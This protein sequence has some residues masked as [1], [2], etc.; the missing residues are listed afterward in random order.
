V[1][2]VSL[3]STGSLFVA[4]GHGVY[5]WDGEAYVE[6]FYDSFENLSDI[7][8]TAE[9]DVWALTW[10]TVGHFDGQDWTW[11]DLEDT[12]LRELWVAPTGEA[13][14]VG[15]NDFR[16]FDEDGA[17]QL[18][19]APGELEELEAIF[20]ASDEDLWAVGY[21]TVLRKD[22]EDWA[23]WDGLPAGVG[24]LYAIHGS[25]PDDIWVT[26]YGHL[27]H[28][29]GATWTDHELETTINVYGVWVH[30]ETSA[31]AAGKSGTV[32]RWDG[33]EWSPQSTGI[34]WTARDVWGTGEDDVWIAGED[35]GL[36]HWDGSAWKERQTGT[37]DDFRSVWT[38]NG[39]KVYLVAGSGVD[40]RSWTQGGGLVDEYESGSDSYQVIRGSDTGEIWAVG[41][42]SRMAYYSGSSWSSVYAPTSGVTSQSN[43]AS[44]SP[45]G[46]TWFAG[47]A[48]MILQR[49]EHP[50]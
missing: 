43:G 24:S 47:E 39:K 11:A 6:L 29:D 14:A 4:A 25:G 5:Q 1:N 16:R 12:W 27:Y 31:W 46:T 40:V 45:S 15:D 2:A 36:L 34:G 50:E 35:G 9:D 22:G 37:T 32:L 41:S 30:S 42:F 33:S 38:A 7:H 18:L 20:A 26:G 17:T 48:R 28:W 21:N 8:A 23:S 49:S 44:V 19:G 13:Y 10:D 3:T